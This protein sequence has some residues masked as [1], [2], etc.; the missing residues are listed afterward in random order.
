MSNWQKLPMMPI[1][2]S[3]CEKSACGDKENTVH[4]HLLTLPPGEHVLPLTER[5]TT[6]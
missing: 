3:G 1:Q 6:S 2:Q 4:A 5:S